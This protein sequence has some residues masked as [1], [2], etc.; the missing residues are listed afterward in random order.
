MYYRKYFTSNLDH[1]RCKILL[2]VFFKLYKTPLSSGGIT[3][4]Y[5]P[6]AAYTITNN[7]TVQFQRILSYFFMLLVRRQL[8][9]TISI[10]KLWALRNKFPRPLCIINNRRKI[11]TFFGK[12]ITGENFRISIAI[13]RKDVQAVLFNVYIIAY[14]SKKKCPLHHPWKELIKIQDETDSSLFF[15][16]DCPLK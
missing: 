12:R 16:Y 8:S 3:L 6:N 15:M 9:G 5:E 10:K 11:N 13:P 1:Q 7:W 2:Q 14:T 4:C